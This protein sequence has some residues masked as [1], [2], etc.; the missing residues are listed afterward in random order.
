RFLDVLVDAIPG[1]SFGIPITNADVAGNAADALRPAT[2]PLG[3]TQ[4]TIGRAFEDVFALPQILAQFC[5]LIFGQKNNVRVVGGSAPV[6]PPQSPR[7]RA[8][9]RGDG[10]P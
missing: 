9:V 6:Q 10:T 7:C 5:I 4:I 2:P 1:A 3:G 8:R